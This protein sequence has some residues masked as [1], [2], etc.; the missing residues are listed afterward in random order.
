MVHLRG[1]KGVMRKRTILVG[2]DHQTRYRKGYPTRASS[3]HRP[4]MEYNR[5]PVKCNKLRHT[6]NSIPYDS[7][8][9]TPISKYA[10]PRPM[11]T[12]FEKIEIENLSTQPAIW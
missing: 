1:G 3:Q 9:P 7:T 12:P 4:Q 5:T 10:Y 6:S 8:D 2:Q 11:M